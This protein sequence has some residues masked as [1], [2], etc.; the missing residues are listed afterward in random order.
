MANTLLRAQS[1]G[2]PTFRDP[3][4]W[5]PDGQGLWQ[6][7]AC[8]DARWHPPHRARV[9]EDSQVHRRNVQ[10]RKAST[11]C[12][13][14][15][16]TS[17]ISDAMG[18]SVQR[19]AIPPSGFDGWDDHMSE[20]A[21]STIGTCSSWSVMGPERGETVLEPSFCDSTLF[22]LTRGL[23]RYLTLQDVPAQQGSDDGHCER[24]VASSDSSAGSSHLH[25][26]KGASMEVTART[27]ARQ[28][29]QRPGHPAPRGRARG[30]MTSASLSHLR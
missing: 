22:E 2:S 3:H 9:H 5:V 20:Y 17:E 29:G 15:A 16:E 30:G 21:A 12:P 27:S 7:Q 23:D 11:A 10:Y 14:N 8:Q 24:S 13:N 6:C 1:E 28:P 18:P 26:L 25:V 19:G 4:Y